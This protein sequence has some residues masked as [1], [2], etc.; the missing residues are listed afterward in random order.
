[1]KSILITILGVG[2]VLA[3]FVYFMSSDTSGI[4]GDSK[5]IKAKKDTTV[6]NATI[7]SS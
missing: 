3:G 5:T 7:P 4:W 6:T 1:M 2:L